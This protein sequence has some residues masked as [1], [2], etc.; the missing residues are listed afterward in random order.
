MADPIITL[1]SDFGD[2]SPYVAAMKGVILDINPAARIVDLSHQI[3]PQDLPYAAFFLASTIPYF[4]RGAIHVV[5]V[6]PGVGTE[7]AILYVEVNGR[8]LLVPDN[9]CWTTLVYDAL[10]CAIRLTEPRY[11]R[12]PLSATF[13]GRDIFAPVAGHLSLG[14][15]PA[16]LGAPASDWVHLA[17][18][19]PLR[20]ANSVHGE[21]LFVDRF[22]N[23]ITNIPADQLPAP[24]KPLRVQI[25]DLEVTRRVQSYGQAEPGSLVALVSSAGLLEIAVAQGNAA[26]RLGIGV[27][28]PVRLRTRSRSPSR[29]RSRSR[30]GTK[31]KIGHGNG[32]GHGNGKGNGKESGR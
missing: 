23:L 26:V 14:V 17:L 20:K 5:V 9:G 13:H 27:G 22:G 1:T 21:V 10:P 12:Q 31:A 6:D 25:G 3:P 24:T 32:N 16:S 29:S 19:A 15:D 11:W 4:P 28:A 18:P 30:S 2:G 7:R 8:R